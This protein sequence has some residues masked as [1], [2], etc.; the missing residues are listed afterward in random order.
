MLGWCYL[1]AFAVFAGLKGKNYYLTPIYPMLLAAGAVV[2][3][4]AIESVGRRWLKPAISVC[5]PLATH[6]SF[7][8]VVPV[9]TPDQFL[10]YASAL[11]FAI[12]RGVE[13]AAWGGRDCSTSRIPAQYNVASPGS[14]RQLW[15]ARRRVSGWL[16][17]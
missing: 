11:P 2:I 8:V 10:V 14:G 4:D 13:G 16:R 1:V 7:P 5:W 12:P 3:A 6:S 15:A 17:V 9:L